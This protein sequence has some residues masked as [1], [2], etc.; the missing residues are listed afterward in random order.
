MNAKLLHLFVI[1]L[2]LLIS[3]TSSRTA[4]SRRTVPSE[5]VQ[6]DIV[7]WDTE[8]HYVL[9]DKFA[10][11]AP[12]PTYALGTR[13]VG[14]TCTR[15][16]FRMKPFLEQRQIM[17]MRLT[18]PEGHPSDLLG[19]E[20]SDILVRVNDLAVDGPD[21][22]FAFGRILRGGESVMNLWVK[23]VTETFCLLSCYWKLLSKQGAVDVARERKRLGCSPSRD[24]RLAI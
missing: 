7:A 17:G 14:P 12:G 9:R 16:R 6:R 24:V 5:T 2:S 10:P 1:P 3:A 13:P 4:E 23:R 20:T 19:L 15:S 18:V 11:K 8:F 21:A 22:I